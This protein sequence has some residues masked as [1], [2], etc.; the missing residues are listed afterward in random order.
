MP[1]RLTKRPA[2]DACEVTEKMVDKWRALLGGRDGTAH[3]WVKGAKTLR[4]GRAW[5]RWPDGL[6]TW[7]GL[8]SGRQ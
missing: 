3:F 2:R 8:A 4:A 1:L 7:R 5:R 6:P